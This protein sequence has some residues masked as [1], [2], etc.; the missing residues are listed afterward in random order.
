MPGGKS[1]TTLPGGF[2]ERPEEKW[3]ALFGP[4]QKG[5]SSSDCLCGAT[6]AAVNP[7]LQD[8][9]PSNTATLVA[10][11]LECYICSS[12]DRKLFVKLNPSMSILAMYDRSPARMGR[13]I[14]RVCGTK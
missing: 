11:N 5:R 6:F 7:L 1:E 10:A 8:W 3:L 4:L 14:A 12:M 2:D 13:F 9:S